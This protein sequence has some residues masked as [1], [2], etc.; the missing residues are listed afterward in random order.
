MVTG[1]LHSSR[2]D[3]VDSFQAAW[4]ADSCDA[5]GTMFEAIFIYMY[6]VIC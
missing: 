2:E 4:V 3:E 5:C 1:S 6:L